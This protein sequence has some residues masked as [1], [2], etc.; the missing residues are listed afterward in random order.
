MSISIYVEVF[1]VSY[2]Q[3]TSE[4]EAKSGTSVRSLGTQDA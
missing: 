1:F 3:S 2:S 4:C